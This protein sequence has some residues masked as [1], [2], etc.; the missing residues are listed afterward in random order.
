MAVDWAFPVYG[1]LKGH[2]QLF[3]GY[4]ESLIDYNRRQTSIGV[5]LSVGEWL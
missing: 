2:V 1:Y 4:G 3:T 5:G